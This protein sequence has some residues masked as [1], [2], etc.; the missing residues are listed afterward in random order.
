M[1]PLREEE[2][3]LAIEGPLKNTGR[4]FEEGVAKRLVEKLMM[5][6]FQNSEGKIK[7]IKGEFVEPVH[8]QI[9]CQNLWNN[10][11]SD[12]TSLTNESL[13]GKYGD[14]K[15]VLREFYDSNIHKASQ[16]AKVNEADL[17]KWFQEK[18]ITPDGTRGIVLKG[19]KQTNGIPNV[20][21]KILEDMH[22][23]RGEWRAGAHWYELTSDRFIDPIIQ[24]NKEWWPKNLGMVNE[25]ESV[26]EAYCKQ[27]LLDEAFKVHKEKIL[28]IWQKIG[29]R[30]REALT[31]S[32]MAEI[33]LENDP[34]QAIQYLDTITFL[35][36]IEE[37]HRAKI[38]NKFADANR[39]LGYSEQAMEQLGASLL[40]FL[41]LNDYSAINNILKQL[42]EVFH[43]IRNPEQVIKLLKKVLKEAVD[44]A[45]EIKNQR[46]INLFDDLLTTQEH[47]LSQYNKTNTV[48]EKGRGG[49]FQG[50]HL[51]GVDLHRKNI[52]HVHM[53]GADLRFANLTWGFAI[54]AR[55]QKANL[56]GANLQGINLESAHLEEANLAF[57]NLRGACLRGVRFDGS[58]NVFL[59]NFKG[60]N[61]EN[62]KLQIAKYSS[63]AILT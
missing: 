63:F 28:P 61:L 16:K 21:V 54:G 33:Y 31:I 48:I 9:I 47:N 51:Q 18:L 49:N 50:K 42:A 40:I 53:E 55:L 1:E 36:E 56:F 5:I 34:K 6:R 24:S 13:E 7:E 10:W 23:I 39:K 26:A 43:E 35:D 22:L 14:V 3:L 15:Q 57:A 27:G 2:A 41:S 38:I 44:H 11:P 4:C 60:T 62:V 17:R 12:V 20:A 25:L 59:A 58:T 19:I 45:R 52:E 8:L 30:T 46:Y 32:N 29:D 37:P